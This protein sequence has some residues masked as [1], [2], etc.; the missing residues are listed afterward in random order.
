MAKIKMSPLVTDIKGS[1]D[2]LLFSSSRGV[3][4]VRTKVKPVQPNT[5]AQIANRQI[6]VSLMKTLG[7]MSPYIRL[8]WE[9]AS[10][11]QNKTGTNLFISANVA[12]EKTQDVNIWSLPTDIQAVSGPSYIEQTAET[13]YSVAFS[14]SPVPAG[15]KL[16]VYNR[17]GSPEPPNYYD[18][19]EYI[20]DAPQ[21]SPV[22]VPWQEGVGGE[23]FIFGMFVDEAKGRCGAGFS[24][25]AEIV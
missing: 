11:G 5:A 14:P 8:G 6:M 7:E 18:I 23:Y 3:A 4:T 1:T 13:P 12:S 20:Y 19:W 10:I 2:K 17:V 16:Y 15:L 25:W 24:A 21:T 9:H 22:S